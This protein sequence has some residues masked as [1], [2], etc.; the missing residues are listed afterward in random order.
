M[1]TVKLLEFINRSGL[2]HKYIA[3]QLSLS[4]Q[5][6]RNKLINRTEFKLSEIK[7]LCKLLSIDDKQREYIFFKN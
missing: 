7:R 1:D 5:G 6:W 3:R 2:K 4:K